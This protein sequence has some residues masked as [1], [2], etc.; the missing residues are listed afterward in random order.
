[1]GFAVVGEDGQPRTI[2][3]QPL[4]RWGVFAAGEVEVRSNWLGAVG[5]RA[6]GSHTVVIDDTFVP[7]ENTFMPYREAPIADG[8]LYRLPFITIVRSALVGIPLGL[9]RRALDELNGVCRKK[10]S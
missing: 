4:Q 7:K 6:S 3:D 1:M 2:S 5:L 10:N 9:A 8:A